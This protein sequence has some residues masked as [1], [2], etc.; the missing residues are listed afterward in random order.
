ME[1]GGVSPT[2]QQ[3]QASALAGME[4]AQ[5]R[6]ADGAAKVA[7]GAIEP[8][9]IVQITSARVDFAA[10]ATV[11]RTADENTRRLLDVLA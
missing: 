3:P 4:S 5:A 6:L 8:E 1:I 7:G 11:F 9:V 2:I 10:N